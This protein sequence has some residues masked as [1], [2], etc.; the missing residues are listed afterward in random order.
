MFM[1]TIL[2]TI[3]VII[4]L[5]FMFLFGACFGVVASVISLDKSLE[6]YG[7]TPSIDLFK[8]TYEE[9]INNHAR[10]LAIELI[11]NNVEKYSKKES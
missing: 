9:V 11:K 6:V 4:L 5:I 10:P 2:I 3:A 7:T 8:R 1:L